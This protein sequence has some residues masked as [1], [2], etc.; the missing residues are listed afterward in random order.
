VGGIGLGLL[1]G[2]IAFGGWMT[3]RGRYW[4]FCLVAGGL[5]L[6][7]PLVAGVPLGLWGLWKLTR[8]EVKA[9]F[10]VR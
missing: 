1:G 3:R 7:S 9:A 5:T 4:Q 6:L 8:P 10:V 2:L